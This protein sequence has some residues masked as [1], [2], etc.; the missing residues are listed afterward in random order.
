MST[1][2]NNETKKEKIIVKTLFDSNVDRLVVEKRR[3]EETETIFYM[4]G[5]LAYRVAVFST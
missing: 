1:I 2:S 3:K 5:L 4:D